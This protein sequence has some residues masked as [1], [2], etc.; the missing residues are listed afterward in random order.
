[1]SSLLIRRARIIDPERG[2]ERDGDILVQDGRIAAIYR[3]P[4]VADRVIEADG[5][6][7]APGF[8]DM[9]V[10]FREPG[11]EEAETI[12]S[13]AEAAVAGG[14]TTVCMMPNTQ[15]PVDSEAAA[16]FVVLQSQRAGFA[17]VLPVGAVTEGLQGERLSEMG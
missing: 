2:E 8:I 17:K 7:A 5:L 9:H 4:S 12:R 11:N 13:G 6:Y 3:T 14:F 10:H 16:E 1:M 15:P